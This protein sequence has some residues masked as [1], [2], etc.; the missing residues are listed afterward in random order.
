M[1]RA[2]KIGL[3]VAAGGHIALFGVLSLSL[4]S[5]PDEAYKPK[6]I[7]VMIADEVGLESASPNPALIPPATSVAPEL[8]DP[9]PADLSEPEPAELTPAPD[10]KPTPQRQKP[11]AKPK[12]KPK[13]K[14]K[15][16]GS[17][18]G[19]DFLKG[20]T[21]QSS[22]S[23]N[24]NVTGEKASARAV[25]SLQQ[26]LYRQLKRQ[27]KPPTGADAEKLRTKVTARLDRSGNIVGT[28][29]ATTSG[30]TPGNRSQAAIHKERAIAAVKLAAPYT[31]FPEKYYSEWQVIEPVLYLGI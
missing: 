26:E 18:L 20:V 7:E 15:P 11:V 21:D 12:P 1:E 22:V 25:A 2:E 30:I 27:W 6:A 10:I 29:S 5:Q 31:T 4:L 28:P 19:K 24:Q 23:R 14:P 16:K 3:G 8:G 13:D 17:R 9:D